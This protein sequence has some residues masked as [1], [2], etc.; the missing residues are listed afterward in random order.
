MRSKPDLAKLKE[1]IS[2]TRHSSLATIVNDAVRMMDG[3]THGD[4]I[5]AYRLCMLP[6]E[7]VAEE[8]QVASDV[9]SIKAFLEGETNITTVKLYVPL[10][11]AWLP[12]LI[13]E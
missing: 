11:L 2:A 13:D 7:R 1:Y 8:N 9:Q 5:E 10:H 6:D 12:L 3:S 4:L